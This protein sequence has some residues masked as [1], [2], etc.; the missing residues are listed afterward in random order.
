MDASVLDYIDEVSRDLKAKS[1]RKV[2]RSF[3]ADMA[4]DN[5]FM[6]R[7]EDCLD[8]VFK[9]N[10]IP[11]QKCFVKKSKDKV[12]RHL[13][14]M[15]SDLHFG[16]NLKKREFPYAYGQTEYARRLAKVMA[17]TA[18]FKPQYRSSTILNMN[19][20]GD[21]IQGALAHDKRDGDPIAEQAA[22][23]IH[24]LTQAITFASAHFWKV[25]V[26]CTPGN[27]GRI[28]SR[29][30]DR[31]FNGKWD[32]FETIIYYAVKQAVAHLKNVEV[33]IPY[34]PYFTYDV[35]GEHLLFTHGDTVVNVGN[36]GRSINVRSLDQQISKLNATRPTG[37]QF[38]IVGV[39]HVH[40]ASRVKLGSKVILMSNG[41]LTPPD[42]FAVGMGT[43]DG[44][45]SQTLFESVPGYPAGDYR[46]LEVGLATDKDANLDKIIKPFTKF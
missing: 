24:L 35:F 34:E 18:E 45:F 11:E 33:H 20:L 41:P 8:R 14:L 23:A 13:N 40:V 30:E 6:S 15:L 39:G 1:G 2:A 29:H 12:E 22:T 28:L 25:V 37:E 4:R 42:G 46:E 17:E 21:I 16:A 10:P 43:L 3:A 36:P 7:F 44:S 38:K 9:N 27:H 31:A 19:L 26:R 5:I 32:S